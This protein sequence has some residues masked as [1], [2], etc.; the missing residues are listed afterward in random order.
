MHKPKVRAFDILPGAEVSSMM[1]LSNRENPV[2]RIP[3]G[4]R[5]Y[6]CYYMIFLFE[7]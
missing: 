3:V 2:P 6:H 5:P 1:Y 7:D 4:D